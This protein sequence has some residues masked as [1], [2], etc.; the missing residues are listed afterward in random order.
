MTAL[1][2]MVDR[3]FGCPPD[4][5]LDLPIPPS[6]NR[7]RRI[8]WKAKPELDAWKKAAGNL[9]MANGQWKRGYRNIGRYELTVILDEARCKKDPDNILKAA[10]DIL[11]A[12]EVI[13]N[14]SP[15]YARRLTVLW[16][17]APE[18]MRL[19]VTPLEDP[20]KASRRAA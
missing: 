6:V 13:V 10:I 3:P 11:R 19:V 2:S 12:F 4:T 7:T 9:L 20:P 8:N 16:G 1:P 14:D 18:G 15:K 17:E 5:I